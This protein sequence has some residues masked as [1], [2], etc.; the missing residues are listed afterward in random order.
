MSE[1]L[2]QLEK[3]CMSSSCCTSLTNLVSVLKKKNKLHK[4]LGILNEKFQDI[5]F[6][7]GLKEKFD[8]ESFLKLLKSLEYEKRS[9]NQIM[10]RKGDSGDKIYIILKGEI[11][12][13][14][15]KSE[16]ELKK[17]SICEKRTISKLF[18]EFSYRASKRHSTTPFVGLSSQLGRSI[19]KL[20]DFDQT[21]SCTMNIQKPAD[22]ENIPIEKLPRLKMS[23]PIIKLAYFITKIWNQKLE[24]NQNLK[25]QTNLNKDLFKNFNVCFYQN[26]I[27]KAYPDAFYDMEQVTKIFPKQKDVLHMKTGD[28]FGEIALFEKCKRQAGIYCVTDCEFAIISRKKEEGFKYLLMHDQKMLIQFLQNFDLFN[29]WIKRYRLT[30]ICPYMQKDDKKSFDDIVYKIGD[31]TNFVYFLKEGEIEISIKETQPKNFCKGDENYLLKEFEWKVKDRKMKKQ[32]KRIIKPCNIFGVEEILADLPNRLF[33][34]RVRSS[35]CVLYALPKD[36]IFIDL[37]FKTKNSEFLQCL[38]KYSCFTNEVLLRGSLIP[39]FEMLKQRSINFIKNQDAFVQIDQNKENVKLEQIKYQNSS[40]LKESEINATLQKDLCTVCKPNNNFRAISAR[41]LDYSKE[42]MAPRKSTI[43]AIPSEANIFDKFSRNPN[44]INERI[45]QSEQ[46]VE[47]NNLSANLK[48]FILK[49]RYSYLDNSISNTKECSKNQI[50]KVNTK[51]QNEFPKFLDFDRESL[52]DF[53]TKIDKFVNNYSSNYK[54]DSPG[55]FNDKLKLFI[56]KNTGR[57]SENFNSSFDN[58]LKNNQKAEKQE[59]CFSF[60]IK[61]H[62]LC[63]NRDYSIFHKNS[64]FGEFQRIQKHDS[65]LSTEDPVSN[66]KDDFL[67][68]LKFNKKDTPKNNSE[69]VDTTSSFFN[70][71]VRAKAIPNFVSDRKI[72]TPSTGSYFFKQ[73]SINAMNSN[74]GLKKSSIISAKKSEENKFAENERKNSQ[75]VIQISEYS[76]NNNLDQLQKNENSKKEEL[77][78]NFE[79][80]KNKL[81]TMVNLNLHEMFKIDFV[82]GDKNSEKNNYEMKLKRLESIERIEEEDCSQNKKIM[83]SRSCDNIQPNRFMPAFRV[84][85]VKKNGKKIEVFDTKRFKKDSNLGLNIINIRKNSFESK[86]II[87]ATRITSGI[88]N[89][90]LSPKF[91]K[92]IH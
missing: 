67:P 12:V 35:R 66:T 60:N 41:N 17:N 15:E 49:S 92:K 20:N 56:K 87:T 24:N 80:V 91:H 1:N 72:A 68:N 40:E 76:I 44:F 26:V 81:R 77:I 21:K 74:F 48:Q 73:N 33:T 71:P 63:T 7:K 83:K 36:K 53:T 13:M 54:K 23:R 25:K 37:I 58:I 46:A 69:I 65:I 55:T 59:N 31:K 29:W 32:F 19:V 14:L 85:T 8:N 11:S 3:K 50:E 62:S 34:A 38:S 43:K 52:I 57:K 22:L 84:K 78:D 5:K 18:N 30:Q 45:K 2:N 28:S 39:N 9:K 86:K 61:K 27:I 47:Y 6:F 16:N 10:F 70:T 88:K 42:T 64:L 89:R 4:D 75:E 79:G 51:K 90:I 82:S